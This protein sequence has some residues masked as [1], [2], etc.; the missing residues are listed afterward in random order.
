M[1][2]RD[3]FEKQRHSHDRVNKN[4]GEGLVGVFTTTDEG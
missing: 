4:T 2:G 1:E 3:E